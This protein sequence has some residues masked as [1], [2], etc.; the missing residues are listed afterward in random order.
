[1]AYLNRGALLFDILSLV[2][3]ATVRSIGLELAFEPTPDCSNNVAS[4]L[5]AVLP[6]YYH[7]FKPES[8][9]KWRCAQLG[10]FSL[11]VFLAA[12]GRASV[13]CMRGNALFFMHERRSPQ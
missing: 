9:C 7:Y 10:A 6:K 3:R 8:A 5:H 1:M 11:C 13:E 2:G 4:K 12:C